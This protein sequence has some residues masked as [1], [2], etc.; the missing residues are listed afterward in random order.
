MVKRNRSIAVDP[1]LPDNVESADSSKSTTYINNKNNNSTT[2]NIDNVENNNSESD[3]DDAD[4]ETQN[5]DTVIKKNGTKKQKLSSSDIQMAR[6]TAE[7]FK[8]N[9][10]KLQIDELIKELKL[11]DS[12]CLLIEKVLHKINSL[13]Q[14]I[15]D[16]DP[17][18]LD[19]A[20]N[21]FKNTSTKIPF[22]DP[23]PNSLN[24]NLQYTAPE[25]VSLIGSF[26]LKTA[27][28]KKSG[29]SIDVCLTMDKSLIQQKDY[30]NYRILYKQA[31]YLAYLTHHLSILAPKNNLPIKLHYDYHNGNKLCPSLIIQSDPSISNSNNSLIFDKTNFSIR[32]LIGLPYGVFES[33][34]LLP[35]RNSIRIQSSSLN[36]NDDLPP[37]PLYNASI[38]SSTTY[39]YYLK[40]L[41]TTKKSTEA[42]KD[43]ASLGSLWL[44]QYGFS[45]NI[46][47]GGF[48][49][50]EFNILMSALLQGGGINGNKI[51]LHGYSSYQLF[52]GTIRYLATQDICDDGYLSF[53]SL[54]DEKKSIF[55]KNGFNI[56][57]IFDKNTK[58]NILWKMS[59]SSYTI[60]KKYAI[61]T[62]DLLND[63]IVDRFNQVFLTNN[64]NIN[65]K[66]DSVVSIPYSKLVEFNEDKFGSLEKISFV[67]LENYLCNKVY[68]ILMEALDDRVYQI[69]V[70][71][72]KNLQ[73]WSINKR[74]PSN[75]LLN[76]QYLIVGLFLNPD[77]SDKRVTKGPLHTEK[78]KGEKFVSFWGDKAQ[79][80]RY[81]DNTVQWSCLWD[82]SPTDSVVLTIVKFILDRHL[83][84]STNESH[85][86]SNNLIVNSSKF[87][88]LLPQPL[89]PHS[90][91]SQPLILP[92]HF[93]KL[94]SAFDNIVKDISNLNLPLTVRNILPA[95]PSL[96]NTSV[97]LPVPFATGD[98]NYFNECIIQFETSH[99]WPDEIVSLENTKTA[100]LL[101]LA[102]ELQ[103]NSDDY[104]NC[105]IIKD[106]SSVPYNSNI[107]VLKILTND[108]YGFQFRI[109]TEMDEF[110]YLKAIENSTKLTNGPPQTAHV[111][112]AYI[113]F[114]QKYINAVKH[115]RSISTLVTHFPYYSATVRLFKQWLDS[116]L[117][118]THI[119]EEAIELIVLQSFVDSAPYG[120][121]NS[122]MVG[123]SRVLKFLANWNWK[124]DPL[125]LELSRDFSHNYREN[126]ESYVD[127]ISDKLDLQTYQLITSSFQK[128]R[129]SD[130]YG[131][132]VPYF[133]GTKEDISGK[134]WT[135]GISLVIAT[136][137]TSISRVALN[138]LSNSN[139]TIEISDN[140]M[141]LLFTPALQD[142]DIVIKLDSSKLS[143]KKLRRLTGIIPTNLKFKN[144]VDPLTSYENPESSSDPVLNFY[145]E[146]I[147]RFGEVIVWS[148]RKIGGLS[149]SERVITG[150]IVPG[151]S[152]RKFRVGMGYP[153]KPLPDTKDMVGLDVED[154]LK[155]CA[156]L[157]GDMVLEINIKK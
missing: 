83:S 48:G 22:P 18:S 16:S 139:E 26:G 61:Q 65:I 72:S 13:I 112:T 73:S 128:L 45:S 121:P 70:K 4:E 94:K 49:H 131:T 23:N 100:F 32:L 92:E 3:S 119:P 86:L 96:R 141:K 140:I 76:S 147:S 84:D 37:T 14:Q 36:S 103:K 17:L 29:M 50:F 136:R 8:S 66:Y 134:I 63:V 120:T 137:L 143:N 47:D 75:N 58:I 77:E 28:N 71:L 109:V 35:D 30:L 104:Y 21:Y 12:H 145:K 1:I 102:N 101:K 5:N 79:V 157:G 82:V 2:N 67:T 6:E 87:T 150:L 107:T 39:S 40:Y 144:L 114:M 155:T 88:S 60:L 81:K 20:L 98:P 129:Q 123:F 54:L 33:R 85:K 55:K 146:L 44:S 118:L 138:V 110:L 154:I 152:A 105:Y 53:S 111:E 135:Q 51:L 149:D 78:E 115:H 68:K 7:L 142:Y 19:D 127:K 9:I 133:I 108:G 62:L 117:I 38:L 56:P 93:I 42:F 11:K 15:P 89:I 156:I 106:D 69:D 116:Q 41:Y 74:K 97:V 46:N 52:K 57:T 27:I 64:T 91:T 43:A 132:K 113:R 151:N 59:K 99:R 24:Y 122:V 10:F 130:P 125:I 80:R 153:M 90:S 95:S 124:E 25:D 126:K 34:K 148:I 31:F